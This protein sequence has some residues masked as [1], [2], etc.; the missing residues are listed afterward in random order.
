MEHQ[1]L[2]NMDWVVSIADCDRQGLVIALVTCFICAGLGF[3][4]GAWLSKSKENY[5]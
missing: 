5:V 3:C 1:F 4:L 2:C